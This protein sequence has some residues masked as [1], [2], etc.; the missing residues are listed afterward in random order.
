MSDADSEPGLPEDLAD[1]IPEI[2]FSRGIQPHRYARLQPGYQYV[3]FLDPKL[4]EHF[5]SA[6][7]VKAA[8]RALVDAARHMRSAG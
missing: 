8:L 6:E 2:G 7:A 5:G 4:W 1:D 3:V